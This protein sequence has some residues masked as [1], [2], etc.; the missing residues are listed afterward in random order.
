VLTFV[1]R[2]FVKPPLA[3]SGALGD[4]DVLLFVCLL[5]CWSVRLFVCSFVSLSSVK[6][7]RPFATWQHL[8][9]AGHGGLSYRVR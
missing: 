5:V 3:Y 9:V 4:G 6:F 2:L 8:S 7:V 1:S